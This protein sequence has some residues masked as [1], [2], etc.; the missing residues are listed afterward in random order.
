M[1][2]AEPN[3]AKSRKMMKP[4]CEREPVALEPDPD[5]LPVATRLDFRLAADDSERDCF[6]VADSD[7][8]LVD[9]A[10]SSSAHE[11]SG[12]STGRVA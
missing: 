12:L 10:H 1:I 7:V 3:E 9:G 4:T 6:A 11:T 5:E 8:D 2:G